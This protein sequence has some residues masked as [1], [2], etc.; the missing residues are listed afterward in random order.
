MARVWYCVTCG[1][2][3]SS[4]GRCFN[5]GEKLSASALPALEAHDDEDE[6]GYRLNG[7]DNADRGR[8]IV[9]L[10]DLGVVHRFEEEELV[11]DA[12]DEARVDDLVSSLADGIRLDDPEE[13][14]SDDEPLVDLLSPG[15]GNVADLTR[16]TP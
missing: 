16:H 8:L 6:V 14:G 2:E 7:W 11:I 5:C 1:Y 13:G 4:K 15:L 12:G 10:N 9:A 3:I